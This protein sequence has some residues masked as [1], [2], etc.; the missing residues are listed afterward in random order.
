M[1]II[2]YCISIYDYKSS[3]NLHYIF[4]CR[5]P[6]FSPRLYTRF[7]LFTEHRWKPYPDQNYKQRYEFLR[8]LLIS[9]DSILKILRFGNF[10]GFVLNYAH[11]NR[12]G[13]IMKK[14]FCIAGFI[15]V[16][17]LQD[18]VAEELNGT[19]WCQTSVEYEVAGVQIFRAAS[20]A[21]TKALS[22][23]N[24]TAALE[25]TNDY[26]QLPP[27]VIVDV[28]ETVLDNSPF[29]ARLV[30]NGETFSPSK[31]DAW[32]EEAQAEAIPGAREFVDFLKKNNVAL[33]Y[34]TNRKDEAPTIKNIRAALDPD[35]TPE[36]V[37]CKYEQT[38]WGNDK[39]SRRALI[40][41][42]HRIIT[43]LGDDYND[44]V[45]LE[46]SGPKERKVNAAA[47]MSFW[48]SKWFML[49]NPLYGSWERALYSDGISPEEI[50]KIKLRHLNTKEKAQL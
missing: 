45:Y 37:L 13:F 16:A 15:I 19:L 48:G 14:I 5:K 3:Q 40:S 6:A 7:I 30:L 29:Q 42:T 4:Y 18:S 1:V 43:L 9:G 34:V 26:Q 17:H 31:W 49:S 27:A 12:L 22:D 41:K 28:D 32:V 10:I 46:K 36:K 21:V 23:S 11:Q 2:C 50:R 25:Q 20:Q 33:F 44:F 38:G 24:W 8:L 47:H 39:T 35:V